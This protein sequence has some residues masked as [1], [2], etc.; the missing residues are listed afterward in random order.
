MR[1]LLAHIRSNAIAYLALGIALGGT[2]YAAVTLPR[3]SIGTKQLKTGAVTS[4]D[5]KNRT[6]RRADL[7]GSLLST[8]PAGLRGPQGPQGPKGDTGATGA[9]GPATGPAGG[10]LAGTY[11]NPQRA[12]IPFVRLRRTTNQAAANNAIVTLSFDTEVTDP[13]GMHDPNAST[14]ITFNRAGVYSVVGTWAWTANATGEREV[15]IQRNG[16][17][18]ERIGW[19]IAGGANRQQQVATL[20]RFAAGDYIELQGA[21]NSGSGL[22]AIGDVEDH[23][24]LAAAWVGP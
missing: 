12:D 14:R 21:Q 16:S 1:R 23:L 22:N 9:T 3:N 5:I 8:G 18:L 20:F 7:A 13:T 6:I 17:G 15:W 4:S 19:V 10:D 2:S 24:T 11:P